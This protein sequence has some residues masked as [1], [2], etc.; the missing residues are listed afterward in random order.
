MVSNVEQ[1]YVVPEKSCL[2]LDNV[3]YAKLMK[4][5]LVIRKNFVQFQLVLKGKE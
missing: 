3:N 1:T 2:N 5:W 4:L